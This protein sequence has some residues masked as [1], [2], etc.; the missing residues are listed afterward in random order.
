MPV[1]NGYLLSSDTFDGQAL[2]ANYTPVTTT[3][4]SSNIDYSTLIPLI[5]FDASVDPITQS[6]CHTLCQLYSGGSP[7]LMLDKILD[8]AVHSATVETMSITL[9]EIFN[10]ASIFGKIAFFK[11]FQFFGFQLQI[12]ETLLHQSSEYFTRL[13]GT[14]GPYLGIYGNL[15]AAVLTGILLLSLFCFVL[16][17]EFV[18]REDSS[19]TVLTVFNGTLFLGIIGILILSASL[20]ASRYKL[21]HSFYDQ[22]AI[23][24]CEFWANIGICSWQMSFTYYTFRRSEP[25]IRTQFPHSFPCIRF[26]IWIMFPFLL[27]VNTVVSIVKIIFPINA[28]LNI[29]NRSLNLACGGIQTLF[30]LM[31]VFCWTRAL[32]RMSQ[33]IGPNPKL[34]TI[35]A[36]GV[37][38]SASQLLSYVF[39]IPPGRAFTGVDETNLFYTLSIYF[40]VAAF[41]ALFMLKV[42]LHFMKDIQSPQ[43][44]KSFVEEDGT[45][46]EKTLMRPSDMLK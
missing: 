11:H 4:D 27:I 18:K 1:S 5:D 42:R 36:H 17:F 41:A 43:I 30:D 37:F 3:T 40:I 14:Y 23:R 8:M 12:P 45:R 44:V 2:C 38:A 35:A 31:F 25:E 29:T 10:N 6:L 28:S 34:M 20:T 7:A 33:C 15:G 9:Q 16:Y 32:Y 46:C 39:V 26:V 24:L 22:R 19:R 13:S 21:L